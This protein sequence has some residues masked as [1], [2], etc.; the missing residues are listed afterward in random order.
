MALPLL[1]DIDKTAKDLLED[2]FGV[3]KHTLKVKADAPS[4][5]GVTT[6]TDVMPSGALASKISFKWA[7]PC[8][9]AFDRIE[10]AGA[11]KPLIEASHIGLLPGLKLEVKCG[12]TIPANVG[13]IYK[14]EMA[15]A[16]VDTDCWGDAR[17]V[18]ATIV[19]GKANGV[20]VGG[21][22]RFGCGPDKCG[23]VQDYKAV[24]A[25]RPFMSPFYVDAKATK[26][27]NVFN[28]AAFY[29][30]A[31]NLALAANVDYAPADKQVRCT[32]GAAHLLPD[33]NTILKLKV[34]TEGLAT[35][36]LKQDFPKHRLT[37]VAASEVNVMKTSNEGMNVKYGLSATLG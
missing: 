13:A 32:V 7:H 8:G 31:S 4:G 9:F 25:Y 10:L 37:V 34:N 16:A 17:A 28:T 2:D 33:S 26:M 35:V 21:G 6:T 18:N 36:S 20:M 30:P 27:F 23:D 19:T 12:S 3:L 11:N 22:V 5:V 24:V 14:H 29:R 15:T 1:K